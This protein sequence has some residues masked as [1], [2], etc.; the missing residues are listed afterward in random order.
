MAQLPLALALPDHASFATFVA[1]RNLAAVE[2]VTS[3]AAGRPDTLWLWG[4]PGS[5]KTHL[6]Q[7]ACRAAGEAG[8]RAMY[9]ALP[10][11][12]PALLADLD[13]VELLALDGVDAAAGDP[14]WEAPLFGILNAFLAG[15]G[16]LLLAA[17]VAPLQCRFTL[18]DLASRATGAVTY[19]LASL[20]DPER[21]R[22]LK[23]HAAARGLDLDVAAADFLVRRVDRDMATLTG[24]LDRLDRAA[25]RAQRRLT[26]PFIRERLASEDGE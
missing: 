4:A 17:A 15:T 13:R 12:E 5:G 23:L 8:R 24:W 21:T 7:A 16:G 19:R 18:P 25:L 3:V 10:A 11:A 20:D 2:H 1:G 26:V 9:V 14:A 6:L 22:A